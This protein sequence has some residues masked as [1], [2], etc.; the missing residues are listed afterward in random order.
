MLKIYPTIKRIIFWKYPSSTLLLT[1]YSG[2]SITGHHRIVKDS[3][4]CRFKKGPSSGK[5]TNRP[6]S[7]NKI[8]WNN[9]LENFNWGF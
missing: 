8:K 9:Y 5:Y 7:I 4:L 6:K 2:K 3:F 1:K